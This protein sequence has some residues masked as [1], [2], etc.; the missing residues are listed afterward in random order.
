[1]HHRSVGAT[2]NIGTVSDSLTEVLDLSICPRSKSLGYSYSSSQLVLLK[3]LHQN[4][5]KIQ[6]SQELKPRH[7]LHLRVYA[8]RVLEQH[9]TDRIF[10]PIK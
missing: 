7:H 8:D 3:D 9:E 2:Q 4:P 1:M 5:Y 10:F 6:L